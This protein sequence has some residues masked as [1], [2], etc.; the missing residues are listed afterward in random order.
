MTTRLTVASYQPFIPTQVPPAKL[1]DQSNIA[2]VERLTA[3]HRHIAY[4]QRT[5][6]RV[7]THAMP[8]A[9]A[10]DKRTLTAADTATIDQVDA[11]IER[12]LSQCQR[13]SSSVS[14]SAAQPPSHVPLIH[15]AY[16]QRGAVIGLSASWPYLYRTFIALT[17][18]EAAYR[19]ERIAVVAW[20]ETADNAF[21]QSRSMT[22][23]QVSAIATAMI[24]SYNRAHMLDVS[25]SA[26]SPLEDVLCW[27]SSYH[28]L[29][30]QHCYS[31]QR[32][33][34]YDSDVATFVP[35][36]IRTPFN[37]LPFHVDCFKAYS[38]ANI[39]SQ[40]HI[41][42]HSTATQAAA[43]TASKNASHSRADNP[44]RSFKQARTPDKVMILC[45]KH[46]LLLCVTCCHCTSCRILGSLCVAAA[47]EVLSVSAFVICIC[48]RIPDVTVATG[49]GVMVDVA[50]V[51]AV[52][53]SRDS[54]RSWTLSVRLCSASLGFGGTGGGDELRYGRCRWR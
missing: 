15:K 46:D 12:A 21:A 36:I 34:A 37:F 19:L 53:M 27:L 17:D 30:V 10:H 2:M 23:R 31:C 38:R 24:N 48:I 22:F 50:G 26:V 44:Q 8:D 3:Q 47:V 9:H 18:G 1:N 40:T 45:N 11:A 32:L 13:A 16:D 29:F 5:L 52:A 35:P 7:L 6:H 20:N 43:A 14:V 42:P 41:Q 28:T 39:Q 25:H 49:G 54:R 4:A 33:L 51:V